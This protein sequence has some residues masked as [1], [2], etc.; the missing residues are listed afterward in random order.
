MG[1]FTDFRRLLKGIANT[2]LARVYEYLEV[3]YDMGRYYFLG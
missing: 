2:E 3:Y 1:Q